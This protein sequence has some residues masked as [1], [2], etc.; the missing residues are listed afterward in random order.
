[1]KYLWL[2]LCI[3]SACAMSAQAQDTKAPV[4]Y[5]NASWSP[6][7][8][9]IRKIADASIVSN[10]VISRDGKYFVYTKKARGQ[11][12]VYVYDIAGKEERLLISD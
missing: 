1:M 2:M 3:L 6:D 11:W 10:P 7:G 8:S 5:Y 12:G 9:K 4:Y